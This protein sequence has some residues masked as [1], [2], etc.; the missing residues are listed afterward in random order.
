MCLQ[1]TYVSPQLPQHCMYLLVHRVS[2][3]VALSNQPA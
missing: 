2:V 1:V 3:F